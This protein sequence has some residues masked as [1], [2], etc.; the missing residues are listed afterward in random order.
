M[1]VK[2]HSILFAFEFYIIDKVLKLLV[3]DIFKVDI[4]LE[5][6]KVTI[7]NSQT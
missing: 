7:F 3:T 4:V 2:F 1:K 6:N 5:F